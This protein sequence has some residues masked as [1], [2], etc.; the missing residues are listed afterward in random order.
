MYYVTVS[1][2]FVTLFFMSTLHVLSLDYL[3]GVYPLF[4]IFLTYIAVMLHDR[5]PIVVKMWRPAYRVFMCIRR[6]W[7]CLSGFSSCLPCSGGLL[8]TLAEPSTSVLSWCPSFSSGDLGS[9]AGTHR[10]PGISL[11]NRADLPLRVFLAATATFIWY[12]LSSMVR[13]TVVVG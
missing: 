13:V 5:Y 7:D 10:I 11:P 6:E 12:D 4:L 9:S 8:S 2:L 3:V 1:S